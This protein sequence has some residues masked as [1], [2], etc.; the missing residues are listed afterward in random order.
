M[1]K[2]I[3]KIRA[4]KPLIHC[5]TNPVTIYDC[6]NILVA[7]GASP[8]MAH[9]IKE[10][11]DV[12]QNA[13]TFVCNLGATDYFDSIEKSIEVANKKGIPVIL[14]PVG[15]AVSSYRRDFAIEMLSRHHIDCMR[16][17]YSE[18]MSI[19]TDQAT[20]PG[21]DNRLSKDELELDKIKEFSKN[22]ETMFFMTGTTDYIIGGDHCVISDAVAP[23][24]LPNML[25][26]FSGSGCMLSSLTGAFLSVENN[27]SALESLSNMY[28]GCGQLATRKA[29]SMDAGSMTFKTIFLD[30][31]SKISLCDGI[32]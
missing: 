13:A 12:T 5:I 3:E 26:R 31:I 29:L 11:A 17:N 30:E 4:K 10:V 20:A 16:G 9:H 28:R 21:I 8:I 18:V 19:I 1:N 32:A 23:D 6:A 14:D 22:N 15:V 2:Y 27:P 24:G 7:V 25:S